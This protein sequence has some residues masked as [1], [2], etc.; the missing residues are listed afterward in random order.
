MM[1]TAMTITASEKVEALPAPATRYAAVEF[2]VDSGLPEL[3]DFFDMEEVWQAYVRRFGAPESNPESVR[4]RQLSHSIGRTAVVSY[5]AEW[6]ADEYIPS[7]HFTAKIE[8]GKPAELFQFPDD[9]SLPGLRE[10][11]QPE[12][13][14]RLVNRHVF[15][16]GTRRLLVEVVRYR[17]GDRAVLR[18][19]VGKAGF[20]VRILKPRRMAS[21]LSAQSL[22]LNSE[23]VVPRL[24]GHWDSG[25]VLWMSEIPGRNL[26]RQ[27]RRGRAPD[28]RP[29]L[30]GLES[31]WNMPEDSGGGQTFDLPGAY[32]RAKRTF[33]HNVRA[34]DAAFG[35]L[36]SAVNALD[37]FIQSWRPSAMA[38]N[39]FYDDQ[40]LVLP[41]GRVAV[42][43]FE[44]AGPG[45]PMLDVGSFL[46]HQRWGSRFGRKSEA[47]EA[48]Y[49]VFR[50][51]ALERFGW[52]E[53]ELNLREA[54][55]LFRIC[56]N[57]VRRPGA[58]WRD[59]L[60]DGLSLVNEALA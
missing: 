3:T 48:Y 60:A 42:V 45:D 14:V 15:A 10:A 29:I 31:L 38:H 16:V 57:A 11:A 43:D 56:T 2:P 47:S 22:I 1:T 55:C 40:M 59:K 12:T 27:I 19:K 28:C 24:A 39:D 37:P 25:G 5:V 23:F 4:V 32:R 54:V 7:L 50:Q 44:E 53:E 34:E 35:G 20:Y 36:S 51:A 49:N 17:P 26:R 30:D 9:P 6:P 21:F 46:A 18:H 52:S 41:D 13:A 33:R 8:R 58:D